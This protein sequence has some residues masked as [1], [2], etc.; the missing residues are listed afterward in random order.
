MILQHLRQ[1]LRIPQCRLAAA[2]RLLHAQHAD[3]KDENEEKH[4]AR[5]A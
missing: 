4:K 1:V 2:E 5:Y 3:S